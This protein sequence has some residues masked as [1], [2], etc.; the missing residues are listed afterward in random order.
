MNQPSKNRKQED[1]LKRPFRFLVNWRVFPRYELISYVL[2][3][4]SVPMLAYGI[5]TYTTDVIRIIILTVLTMYS[6]FF[7]ALI[8]NDIT[9]VDI[10]AVVHPN[11]PITRGKISSKKFFA[12]ALIFSAMTFIFAFLVSIWCLMVVGMAALF[13][14]F[15]NK[16][17][18]KTIKIP[19]YSEIFTPIQWVVVAIFGF[20]AIWAVIPQATDLA[21]TLPLLGTISTNGSEVQNMILLVLFT[22]F[23]DN[24]HDLPEG[25]HDVEGDR[26][27]GVKTY[28]TSFG[29]K[30]AAFISFLMFLISGILGILLFIQTILSFVFL[31]PFICIWI[32]ILHWSYKLVKA[33]KRD[34][35]ELGTLV[36]RKGFDYFLISYNLIFLD[37][38]LQLINHHFNI[39]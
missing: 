10:D 20:V 28:A 31:I 4:A 22:Y 12:I 13:V 16:F 29:I 7:A 35:K 34:M 5:Q 27:L 8:W 15:H 17:L 36:G 18:K 3:Y 23:A 2:M 14:T 11:R 30:N 38:L 39:L 21:L 26:K 24:A 33:D 9:D 19:A 32:Y 1:L 25:I 6:G 37:I